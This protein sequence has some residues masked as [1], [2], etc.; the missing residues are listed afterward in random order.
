MGYSNPNT[1]SVLL[2]VGVGFI[3]GAT[4]ALLAFGLSGAGDGWN[5]AFISG[6][7]VV[8]APLSGLAWAKREGRIGLWLAVLLVGSAVVADVGMWSATVDEG[9]HYAR[10]AWR[11][12]KAVVLIWALLWSSWQVAAVA[13]LATRFGKRR[14]T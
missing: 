10:A 14:A 7:S 4:V 9:V 5:S 12:S 3:I 13:V 1:R 2:S 11:G 8:L 6:V